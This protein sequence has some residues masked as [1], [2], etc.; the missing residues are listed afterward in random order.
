MAKRLF[1]LLIVLPAAL[2]AGA[3]I[4][5]WTDE[6]GRVHYG[7][8]K[9]KAAGEVEQLEETAPATRPAESDEAR[10]RKEKR[11]RLLEVME[12][13]RRRKQEEKAEAERARRQAEARCK[14]FRKR[15][16]TTWNAQ[17]L[18]RKGDDGERQ[19]LSDAERAE[20]TKRLEAAVEKWCRG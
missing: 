10:R 4:Y 20:E 9:E 17:Y 2:P 14:R 8:R 5:K 18:Y 12:E 11:R 16:Q 15:L 7:D 3:E 19:V 1:L 6:Q 13:D